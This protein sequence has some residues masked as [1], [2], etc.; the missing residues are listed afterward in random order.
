MGGVTVEHGCRAF[1]DW[2]STDHLSL[3]DEGRLCRRSA[4]DSDDPRERLGHID[5]AQVPAELEPE[6]EA[7]REAWADRT[8]EDW[9]GDELAWYWA[10]R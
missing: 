10:T 8:R 4:V 3:D 6:L 5:A 1:E 2:A 7:L 9:D